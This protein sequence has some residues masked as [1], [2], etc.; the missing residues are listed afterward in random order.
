MYLPG[1]VCIICGVFLLWGEAGGNGVEQII[2]NYTEY[3]GCSVS[4]PLM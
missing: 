2:L 1:S 4:G 3:F